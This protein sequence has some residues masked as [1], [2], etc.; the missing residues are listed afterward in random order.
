[1]RKNVL[2]A[3]KEEKGEESLRPI[4]LDS[5]VGQKKMKENLKVFMDSAKIRKTTLDHMLFYGPPGLGKTTI[6]GVIANEMGSKMKSITGPAIERVGDLVSV[7]ASLGEGDILFI[8]EIHRI[9]CF[10]EEILYPAMEDFVIDI[11]LGDNGQ[12]RTIRLDLPRFTLIGATT[13]PGLLSSPLRDRFGVINKLELYTPDELSKIVKRDAALLKVCILK[14]ACNEIGKRSRGTPRIAIRILK[15]LLDFAVV[16]N[17]SAPVINKE[18]A[19]FGLSALDIDIN[20]LDKND[21]KILKSIHEN[22][23]DGPVG[24]ETLAAFISEDE[25]TIEDVYEPYLMQTGFLAKTPRGRI[26]TEKG[27]SYVGGKV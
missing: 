5:Y 23:K 24:I 19:D 6:A 8:D 15:R 1:M 20:G 22:F 27:I 12:S 7:M 9:P 14:D 25:R 16:K 4:T 13:R 2:D 21:L 17:P 26:L 11:V 10:I 3:E 18:I